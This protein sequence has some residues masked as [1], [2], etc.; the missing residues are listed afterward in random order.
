LH[1]LSQNEEG[2]GTLLIFLIKRNDVAFTTD[3]TSKNS[4]SKKNPSNLLPLEMTT[5]T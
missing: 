4:D 2:R 1:S 3:W 5:Q